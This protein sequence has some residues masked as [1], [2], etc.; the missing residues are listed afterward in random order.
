MN[1]NCRRLWPSLRWMLSFLLVASVV[2][3]QESVGSSGPAGAESLSPTSPASPVVTG[4]KAP[5]AGIFR[6]AAQADPTRIVALVP[7]VDV[8]G[9]TLEGGGHPKAALFLPDVPS[10]EKRASLRSKTDPSKA[11]VPSGI[12]AF[13][14]MV[15]DDGQWAL[16]DLQ[17]REA[18][19]LEPVR[20]SQDTRVRIFSASELA[21]PSS[22]RELSL[23][24]GLNLAVFL[25]N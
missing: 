4:Q 3:A 16:V 11:E 23:P 13:R 20:Q 7:M 18:S 5:V 9:V 24:P 2:L 1:A 10:P 12:V 25:A 15:S 6:P 14:A 19:A 17:A 21:S 22:A 8:P